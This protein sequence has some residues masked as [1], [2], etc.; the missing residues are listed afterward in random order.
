MPESHRRGRIPGDALPAG[1][2]PEPATPFDGRDVAG[3]LPAVAGVYRMLGTD[4]SVLYVG[5]AR[6]LRKRVGSY[7][8]RPQLEPRLASMVAQIAAIEVTATRTESEALLLENELIKSLKPRYNVLLRDAKSYPY[9]F[10]STGESFPR[11]GFHRGAKNLPGRYF[12]PF[13]SAT[14]VRES[15]DAI[16]R[17]F[18]LR[19]C[20]DSVFRNR[21]RPCLQHQI[22]RCSAPCVGLIDPEAY[23]QDVQH[24]QMFYEGRSNELIDE[25][26]AAM[27]RAAATLDFERAAG[28]RD[29]IQRLGKVQAR[30][31]V[32]HSERNTD[33]LG[34]AVQDGH[35]CVHVLFFRNGISLGSR[36]HFPR[37]PPGSSAASVLE[38][39][40]TQY[41]LDHPPPALLITSE[42]I[43]EGGMIVAALSVQ[44]GYKVEIRSRVRGER[45][46]LARMAVRNAELS[47]A[48]ELASRQTQAARW[49]ALQE[50]AGVDTLSRVE[51]F[52]I[53]HTMGEATVASCVVFGPE[54][55]ERQA[56]RRFNIAG[57]VG[58]DDYAAMQQALERRYRR[59]ADGELPAP[60]VLLIDGGA[61]QVGRAV[62]VL[63]SLGIDA[64]RIVGVAKGA[65]R[66]PGEEG[67]VFADGSARHPGSG[68]A[69]LLM[70]QTI[71]DEAHRF[72]ITGHRAR[73]ARK[74]ETSSLEEIQGVGSKRRAALLKH[75]GGWSGLQAAGVEELLTVRGIHRELAERIYAVLHD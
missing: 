6:D 52:D 40:V 35:A 9:A 32:N 54:G 56:Y 12:G 33:V 70:I 2:P 31:H 47:L 26:G 38:A 50:L 25:L 30:H 11:I 5:K 45:A 48:I 4:A 24:A 57:I 3:R 29:Q 72:A 18:R 63:K 75:F 53:S 74:R 42:A 22:G 37:T 27:D 59:V 7:F 36:S 17:T 28:I 61:G 43:E 71:R 64:V 23:A 41:Y 1:A 13:P 68:H 8:A 15:I 55:A 67:I 21:S 49:S 16:L 62:E 60:D 66:R 65:E 39:F 46:G 58:G 73:R 14:A 69:G 19:S 44:A 51:C 10:I 20:E 34:C